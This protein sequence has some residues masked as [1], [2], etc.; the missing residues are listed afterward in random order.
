MIWVFVALLVGWGNAG[1]SLLGA[2]GQLPGGS[3]AHVATGVALVA[4]SLVIARRAGLDRAAIGLRPTG[5]TRGAAIGIA[6]GAAI[7]LAGVFGLQLASFIVGGPV[8]Y[9][10]LRDMTEADLRR[11][12]LFLLPL[13]AVL[14]EEIAFRGTL[15]GLLR[16]VGV[17]AAV[18][19]S[20]AAFAL[21]HAAVAIVTV[22][23]TT[24]AAPSPWFVP[25][26]LGALAVV[27]AGGVV[28]AW[29]RLWTDTLATTIAAHWVFNATLLV[30]LWA[31]LPAPTPQA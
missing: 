8:V 12:V 1:S 5:W 21:W 19:G 28:L 24:V 16:R 2:T 26:I 10:P 29:L 20:A 22:G 9:D 31:T 15:V 23:E 14:P 3:L 18:L 13:G 7:A 25:A 11:H 6:S 4:V 17:R 27:F 30:G